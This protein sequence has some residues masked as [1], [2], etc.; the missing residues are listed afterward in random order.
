MWTMVND[1][2]RA[3]LRG[4]PAVKAIS[5]ELE[6]SV[7]DGELTPALGAARILDAFHRPRE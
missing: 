7:L 1:R 3:E 5:A 4:H 6:E 2:L